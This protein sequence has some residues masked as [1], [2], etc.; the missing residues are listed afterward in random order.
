MTTELVL[1]LC[2]FAFV[3][4]GAIFGDKGP[5]KVLAGSSP[6]LGARLEQNIA[7]GHEF[8]VRDLDG[9]QNAVRW[10]AP[11]SNPPNGKL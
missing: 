5:F 7:I 8:K 4:A 6:R 10:Q 9:G 2:V 11:Q 3:T 1:L